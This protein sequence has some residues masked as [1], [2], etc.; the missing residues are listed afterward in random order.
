MT[1]RITPLLAILASGTSPLHAQVRNVGD[2]TTREISALDRAKTV[3]NADS[4]FAIARRPGWPG[5]LGAPR[6]ATAEIGKRS[7]MGLP[8]PR[9]GSRRRS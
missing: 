6:L 9:F 1:S 8:E 7:G 4:G 3:I 5:Y 2:L